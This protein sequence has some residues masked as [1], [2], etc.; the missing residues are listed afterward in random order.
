MG[1]NMKKLFTFILLAA[2]M[3]RIVF[4]SA[5]EKAVLFVK[6]LTDNVITNVLE[7]KENQTKNTKV[8]DDN[9]N[10][11]N[12]PAD[13]EIEDLI[14]RCTSQMDEF[15]L[16]CSKVS[17]RSL[18][19]I[20]KKSFTDKL[21]EIWPNELTHSCRKQRVLKLLREHPCLGSLKPEILLQRIVYFEK[22]YGNAAS[23]VHSNDPKFPIQNTLNILNQA[24]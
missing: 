12:L 11:F 14:Q 15:I 5:D 7:S 10:I 24:E 4:A 22:Q 18:K 16:D 9:Y 8:F 1:E 19:P 3:P 20:L 21:K 13:N 17:E 2:L 23:V 6:E